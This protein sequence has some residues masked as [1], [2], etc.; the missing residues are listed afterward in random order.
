MSG[1]GTKIPHA[2]LCS[3]KERKEGWKRERK[4]ETKGRRGSV[5]YKALRTFTGLI[6]SFSLGIILLVKWKL[7]RFHWQCEALLCKTHMVL[8][9][10]GHFLSFLKIL[11]F[12]SACIFWH[13]RFLIL[14]YNIIYLAVLD[15]VPFY[16]SHLREV[17]SY[18]APILTQEIALEVLL[19]SSLDESIGMSHFLSFFPVSLYNQFPGLCNH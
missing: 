12:C 3:Q 6:F 17:L 7:P 5:L 8:Q 2:V 11:M 15:L 19:P 1:L 13:F 14:N 16:I 4:R 18:F 10:K 9:I